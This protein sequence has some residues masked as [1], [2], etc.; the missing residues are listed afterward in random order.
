[1]SNLADVLIEY[2]R[3]LQE[4]RHHKMEIARNTMRV[5]A[6][7]LAHYVGIP[8]AKTT[9]SPT[10]VASNEERAACRKTCA[11]RAP[12]EPP[13]RVELEDGRVVYEASSSV[14][15]PGN[16]AQI[17]VGVKSYMPGSGLGGLVETMYPM[18]GLAEPF[19]I[20]QIRITSG[21]ALTAGFVGAQNLVGSVSVEIPAETLASVKHDY[22]VGLKGI[23]ITLQVKNTTAEPKSCRAYVI[24]RR[25]EQPE[26]KT[27]DLPHVDTDHL[28]AGEKIS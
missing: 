8:E 20:E 7:L 5:A 15:E 11:H 22:S 12:I 14:V 23:A 2:L 19:Q 27:S 21:F 10:V 16:T 13:A 26:P 1:M 25:V 17:L 6:D 4:Q 18:Y 28:S 24:G 9:P 3:Y